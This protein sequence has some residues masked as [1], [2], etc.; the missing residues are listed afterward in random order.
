MRR[1]VSEQKDPTKNESTKCGG[2]CYFLSLKSDI[3]LE[4]EEGNS[5]RHMQYEFIW[6]M[7]KRKEEIISEAKAVI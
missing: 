2:H 1:P 3:K 6:N 7:R 4:F 5:S